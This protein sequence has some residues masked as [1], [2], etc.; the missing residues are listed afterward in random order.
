VKPW[1]HIR[2]FCYAA[3]SVALL[4][5]GTNSLAAKCY[6]LECEPG[7]T[8]APPPPR[9][10]PLPP[11]ETPPSSPPSRTS[12]PRPDASRCIDNG[13]FDYCVSSVLAPQFGFSYGPEK[14]TDGRLDTAWVEGKRGDGIGE[15]ILVGFPQARSVNSV[16]LLN[17]Y[18]KNASIYAKNNRVQ[19]IEVRTSN[20]VS[21]FETLSDSSGPQT[22]QL[23][24]TDPIEWVQIVIRSVYRGSK[25][26]DTAITELRVD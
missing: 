2:A 3:I 9:Q 22:V 12:L 16:Q 8:P 17:G 26:R 13:L 18:H 24:D 23:Q 15:W 14:A 11:P 25:Y 19:D 6:F 21:Q 7:D 20:G 10:E 5:L 1:L 4:F